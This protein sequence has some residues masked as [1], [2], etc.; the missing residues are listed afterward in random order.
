MRETQLGPQPA[1][2]GLGATWEVPEHELMEFAPRRRDY[3]V[4]IPVINE[5]PRIA[6]LLERMRGL[7]IASTADLIIVD[8]G[9][10]D[11]SLAATM[12]RQMHVRALVVKTGV[13]KLGAQLRCGYAYALLEGYAGIVTIDGNDKDD[14]EA[15]PRFVEEL[16]QG[17]DFVQASRFV[18]GGVAEHTPWL[19]WLAIRAIHAPALS[20]AS[21]FQ[22]TDTTQGFRGYSR[23]LLL[24][25]RV[26]PFRSV[27]TTYEMLAY[28]SYVAPRL[29]FSCKELPTA[30]RYPRGEVP[31]KI[32]ALRGNL[33]L[34]RILAKTCLGAYGP[35]RGRGGP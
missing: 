35:I 1:L 18:A 13:G 14:P 20:L 8:G 19:R 32:S 9:S 12:L 24:D 17:R 16:R 11:G 15:I 26:Q 34:M 4:V 23:R 21:G 25:E 31:T 7:D 29:G 22:W 10:R 2:G 33:A 6:R 5:G 28:L 3:C 30:R 27:F